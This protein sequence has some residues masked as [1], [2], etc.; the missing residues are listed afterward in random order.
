MS[1]ILDM[2]MISVI[3]CFIVDVSGVMDDIRRMVARFI[4]R[5]TGLKPDWRELKLKPIGCSL[6]SV[7]WT[8]IAYIL[9]KD[10]LS[11]ENVFY[12]AV[13]SL[14]SSNISGFLF[15]VKDALSSIGTLFK[16]LLMKI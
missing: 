10:C 5:K 12:A 16:K 15:S 1:V 7:W 14:L 4:G 2:V 6:C 9:F 11:I 3:V 13:L 8:C